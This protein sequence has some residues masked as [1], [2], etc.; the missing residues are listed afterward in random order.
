MTHEKRRSREPASGVLM[1]IHLRAAVRALS[2]RGVENPKP[3]APLSFKR[4]VGAGGV[5]G[6]VEPLR[7]VGVSGGLGTITTSPPRAPYER[8]KAGVKGGPGGG[9]GLQ[10]P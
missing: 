10:A 4:A 3:P 8:K 7:A 2:F 6:I 1:I 5:L 9:S